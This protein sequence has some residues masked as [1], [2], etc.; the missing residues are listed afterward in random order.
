MH[1][2]S[3]AIRTVKMLYVGNPVHDGV[4]F[5]SLLYKTVIAFYCIAFTSSVAGIF[6]QNLRF[7]AVYRYYEQ[8]RIARVSMFTSQFFRAS[9]KKVKTFRVCCST[10]F[11]LCCEVPS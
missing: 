6:H 2:Y 3:R 4:V 11:I 7:P 5:N 1:K 9:M 8:F 10:T